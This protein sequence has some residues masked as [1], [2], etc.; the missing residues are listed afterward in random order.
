[1]ALRYG[2]LHYINTICDITLRYIAFLCVALRCITLHYV[3][4][5]CITFHYVALILVLEIRD[6]YK[7][8]KYFY[9]NNIKMRQLKSCS[10]L[11]FLF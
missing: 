3:A 6:I 8:I 9:Y 2:M 10:T 4:L 11:F 5:R 1:M 7:F